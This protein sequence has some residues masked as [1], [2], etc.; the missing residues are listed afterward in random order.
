MDDK[1]QKMIQKEEEITNGSGI[2]RGYLIGNDPSNEYSVKYLGRAAEKICDNRVK[3]RDIIILY[4]D[5]SFGEGK[6]GFVLSTDGIYVKSLLNKN[7]KFSI[8]YSD[9]DFVYHDTSESKPILKIYPKY[10]DCKIID[11]PWFNLEVLCELIDAIKEI[12]DEHDDIKLEW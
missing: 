8:P 9:I 4:S 10:D 2:W 1:K 7:S 12:A 3:W 11:H 5:S 6:S